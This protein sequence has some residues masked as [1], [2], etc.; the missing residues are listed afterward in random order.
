WYAPVGK[1]G[2][3][4]K[5]LAEHPT[6]EVDGKPVP[7]MVWQEYGAGKTMFVGIDSTWRWRFRVE[8]K[9]FGR[10]WGHLIR[11]MSRSK[12]LGQSRDIVCSRTIEK[13]QRHAVRGNLH[14]QEIILKFEIENFRDKP[15]TLDIFEQLNRVAAEYAGNPR[16]DV[17][18]EMGNQTSEEIRFTYEKGNATPALH[19]KLAARP[20]DPD[21]KVQKKIVRFH[22]T[23]KN[24]W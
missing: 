15:A 21:E 14:H 6:A 19:V 3:H 23:L 4:G 24:I 20:Q 8:D 13:N 12:I 18:W 5:V 11:F 22:F 17:E 9:Y 16:G 7:L 1:V 2:P 10:Y